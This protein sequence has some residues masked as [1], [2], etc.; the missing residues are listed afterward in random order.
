MQIDHDGG[1]IVAGALWHQPL[2]DSEPRAFRHG[3]ADIA[4]DGES[5]RVVPL[6]EDVLQ[7]IEIG[8]DRNGLEEI[9]RHELDAIEQAMWDK[10]VLLATLAG[11]TCLM[12]ATVGDIAATRS[13]EKLTLALL[14][15]FAS[16]AFFKSAI[17]G[18]ADEARDRG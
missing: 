15:A 12:R 10:W 13:G 4:Q 5:F 7:Q 17:D 14:A 3:A 2:D 9:S 11:I 16:V 1:G 18:P 6:L 8:L